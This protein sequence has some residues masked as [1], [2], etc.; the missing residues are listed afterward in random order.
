MTPNSPSRVPQLLLIAAMSL[1]PLL[2]SAWIRLFG[3]PAPPNPP[4]I[5]RA[6]SGMSATAAFKEST[7][8]DFISHSMNYGNVDTKSL[9]P[10]QRKSAPPQHPPQELQNGS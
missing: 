2:E 5:I 8:F 9:S 4:N 7:I 6:P 10:T 1:T 3:N